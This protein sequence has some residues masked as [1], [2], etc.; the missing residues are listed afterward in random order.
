MDNSSATS[1]PDI[2]HPCPH[3]HRYTCRCNEV[4]GAVE[5][6]QDLP[7]CEEPSVWP[8]W[9]AARAANA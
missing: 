5:T 7:L 3:C 8:A 6:L 2:S 1:I 4:D 9:M